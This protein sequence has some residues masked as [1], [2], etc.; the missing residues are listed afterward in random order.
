MFFFLYT[1]PVCGRWRLGGN[2]IGVANL[3]DSGFMVLRK[4]AHGMSV[5]I[6]SEEQQ[7][8][9]PGPP[10]SRLSFAYIYDNNILIKIKHVLRIYFYRCLDLLDRM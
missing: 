7:H 8:S 2:L 6:K 9:W 3:G 5:V 1:F 10:M 4:G